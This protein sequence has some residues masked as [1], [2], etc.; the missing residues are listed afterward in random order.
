MPVLVPRLDL[1]CRAV[2]ILQQGGER[3][4]RS[5]REPRAEEKAE[6]EQRDRDIEF[7][8]AL[9]TVAR[10]LPRASGDR[11]RV[12][13]SDESVAAIRSAVVPLVRDALGAIMRGSDVGDP[14]QRAA[15]ELERHRQAIDEEHR[16]LRIEHSKE[17]QARGR[18]SRWLAGAEPTP[19][20]NT[21]KDKVLSDENPKLAD[22]IDKAVQDVGRIRE[23]HVASDPAVPAPP[24]PPASLPRSSGG[25]DHGDRSR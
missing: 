25:R 12:E 21:A 24:P 2:S 19:D 13:L 18:L 1:T 10:L 8:R 11:R 15:A 16:R 5:R 22:R 23:R 7:R 9:K 4:D 20:W 3:T 6:K 17:E 14:E